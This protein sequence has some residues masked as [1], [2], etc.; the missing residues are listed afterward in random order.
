MAE[1]KIQIDE[2]GHGV[3]EIDGKDIS[4][5][6]RAFAITSAPR[7]PTVLQLH[8]FSKGTLEGDGIVEVLLPNEGPDVREFLRGVDRQKLEERALERGG[9]Q[10]QPG[11]MT[12][13]YVEVLL[14][15]VNETE[16]STNS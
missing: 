7:E 1:F 2:N 10:G 4:R 6:T 15:M 14:E 13:H 8:M 9:W 11:T 3:V 12:D 5:E 16:S